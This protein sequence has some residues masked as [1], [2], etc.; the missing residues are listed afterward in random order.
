ML[1]AMSKR[2][3]VSK[4]VS[5]LTGVVLSL[6]SGLTVIVPDCCAGWS[7]ASSPQQSFGANS[8]ISTDKSSNNKKNAGAA[9][10]KGTKPYRLYNASSTL[11]SLAQ[12]LDREEFDQL[13]GKIEHT[14]MDLDED[15]DP[16]RNT[17]EAVDL[18]Y[19]TDNLY[20][21]TGSLAANKNIGTVKTMEALMRPSGQGPRPLSSGSPFHVCYTRLAN[22]FVWAEPCTLQQAFEHFPEVEVTPESTKDRAVH[23]F[24]DLISLAEQHIMGT[25]GY[26][27]SL[28]FDTRRPQ[29]G[30]Y[31]CGTFLQGHG[32]AT[33]T[34]NHLL[35]Q[36]TTY[37]E[38]GFS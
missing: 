3:P 29:Y 19:N 4:L 25:T 8:P 33:H 12:D 18:T 1:L 15:K 14:R 23:L 5:A 17:Q 20:T 21:L 26:Y 32:R 7:P 10:V 16:G 22:T 38:E 34:S 28:F 13:C 36:G 24:E 6:I 31:G 11:D 2:P 37:P 27:P 35:G 9:T 30:K